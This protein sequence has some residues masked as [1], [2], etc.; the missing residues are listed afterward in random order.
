VDST[1]AHW[2]RITATEELLRE[3]KALVFPIMHREARRGTGGSIRE[4]A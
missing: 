2:V 4:F 1:G 3:A